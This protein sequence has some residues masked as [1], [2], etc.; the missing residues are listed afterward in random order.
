MVPTW[1]YFLDTQ[2]STSYISPII[3]TQVHWNLSIAFPDIRDIVPVLH[4]PQRTCL[5][6]PRFS[7]QRQWSLHNFNLPFWNLFITIVQFRTKHI[8]NA[9][10]IGFKPY[11][12]NC[13][14]LIELN[15]PIHQMLAAPVNNIEKKAW[16]CFNTYI[17]IS[18]IR[19]SILI[20][21]Q[22]ILTFVYTT[23][24]LSITIFNSFR[25]SKW[26]SN[27]P[28]FYRLNLNRTESIIFDS[29][30]LLYIKVD[31]LVV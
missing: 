4:P 24:V 7:L 3:A 8:Y 12:Y 19:R 16:T 2:Q 26:R 15:S 28:M 11:I 27:V 13:F 30:Q 29:I 5:R 23:H 17:G 31:R 20:Y 10:N 18:Y 25:L 9:S 14:Y 6:T 22:K 1:T 21:S